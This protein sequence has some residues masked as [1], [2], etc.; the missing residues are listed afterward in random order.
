M[1]SY[2]P[3]NP[4]EPRLPEIVFILEYLVLLRVFRMLARD[5]SRPILT[6]PPRVDRVIIVERHILDNTAHKPVVTGIAVCEHEE[7]PWTQLML[8]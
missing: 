6:V 1:H 5:H 8:N 4:S 2:S 7:H 3:S